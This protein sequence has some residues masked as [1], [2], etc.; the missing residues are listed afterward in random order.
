MEH[1]VHDSVLIINFVTFLL[2]IKRLKMNLSTC[3]PKQRF[4]SRIDEIYS[5]TSTE[6]WSD[7]EFETS[8]GNKC[9]RAY[10]DDYFDRDSLMNT[11]SWN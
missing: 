11:I 5:G 9:E 2:K 8:E 10:C 3:L 4:L 6:I 1:L 7:P